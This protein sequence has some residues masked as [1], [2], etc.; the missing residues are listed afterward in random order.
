[1]IRE[2]I[3]FLGKDRFINAKF[4]NTLSVLEYA[5]ARKIIKSQKAESLN[6]EI[7][8]HIAEEIRHA[9]ILKKMA[10]QLSNQSLTT[11]RK[12]HLLAGDAAWDY[13][14]S[15]DHFVED[16]IK[17]PDPWIKYLYVTLLI[18]E[19]A[20]EVY[21]LYSE[22]LGQLGLAQPLQGLIAEEE[23]H[24]KFT[25]RHILENDPESSKRLPQLRA[26]E[27]SQF[28]KF[29]ISAHLELA[30]L[31]NKDGRQHHASPNEL[32]RSGNVLIK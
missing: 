5:G 11:Y 14:Q 16:E 3:S 19:R 25:Q 29:M 28:D 27:K 20:M 32:E 18:E 2:V 9:R 6:L 8:R 17:K 13:I 31:N 24:L 26:F 10:L 23:T 4:L 1:M 21:P 15:V 22:T 30:I 12:E 7:L